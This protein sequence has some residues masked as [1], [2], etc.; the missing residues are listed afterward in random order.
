MLEFSLQVLQVHN[1]HWKVAPTWMMQIYR[2]GNLCRR[3]QLMVKS[4]APIFSHL[5]RQVT[6]ELVGNLLSLRTLAPDP[7]PQS[8]RNNAANVNEM[9]VPSTDRVPTADCPTASIY[10]T[11]MTPSLTANPPLPLQNPYTR[12]SGR[13]IRPIT[14]YPNDTAVVTAQV[15][16]TPVNRYN[17][18]AVQL[19]MNPDNSM[20]SSEEAPM[21]GTAQKNSHFQDRQVFLLCRHYFLFTSQ[22]GRDEDCIPAW[23]LQS[24]VPIRNERTAYGR[25]GLV[26]NESI[27]P[28]FVHP[29]MTSCND[30]LASILLSLLY[31]HCE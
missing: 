15:P 12:S 14:P 27:L 7:N 9:I 23:F 24:H 31:W 13:N 26:T 25:I 10:G 19:K 6:E 20:F 22:C 4:K 8:T 16:I 17:Q 5:W 28:L 18:L 1:L 11:K 3:T 30:Y 21:I 2:L 29:R